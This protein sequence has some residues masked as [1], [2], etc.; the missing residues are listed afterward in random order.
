MFRPILELPDS[1]AAGLYTRLSKRRVAA[2]FVALGWSVRKCTWADY[3]IIGP[4]AEL[5]IEA[6]APILIHG[7]MAD[8][9]VNAERILATL[10]EAGVAYDAETYDNKGDLLREF[11]WVKT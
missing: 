1:F 5:V 6:E 11:R 7:P 9:G 4:F 10:R 8:A 3:E 2:L